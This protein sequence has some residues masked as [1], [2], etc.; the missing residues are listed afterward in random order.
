MQRG[1]GLPPLHNL[2][3]AAWVAVVA[4]VTGAAPGDVADVPACVLP[5]CVEVT[6]GFFMS[7]PIVAI[8]DGD[9]VQWR[10][11]GGRHMLGESGGSACLPSAL[12]PERP[13]ARVAFTI[14]SGQLFSIERAG[15]ATRTIACAGAIELPNGAFVL[16]YACAIHAREGGVG[17][18][19]VSDD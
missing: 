6:H 1:K 13:A 8:R 15:N 4:L 17:I 7:R 14:D 16:R 11:E 9:A 5:L 18:L 19:L 12:T 10:S 2:P 3:Y